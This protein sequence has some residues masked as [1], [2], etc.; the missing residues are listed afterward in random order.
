MTLNE[1]VRALSDM[2]GSHA[3]ALHD[4]VLKLGSAGYIGVEEYKKQRF[5]ISARQSY[6]VNGIFPMIKR[7]ELPVEISNAEYQLDLPSLSPWAI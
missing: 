6:R 3:A 5:F 7:D 1:A 2:M 4:F